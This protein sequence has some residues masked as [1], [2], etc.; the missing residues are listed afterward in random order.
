MRSWASGLWRTAPWGVAS[1]PARS[2]S[3]PL[4]TAA[5]TAT[6]APLHDRSQ[7]RTADRRPCSIRQSPVP[8]LSRW[9]SLPRPVHALPTDDEAA[10]EETL[11]RRHR[12]HPRGSRQ[13]G[14]P[15]PRCRSCDRPG[16]VEQMEPLIVPLSSPASLSPN[17]REHPFIWCQPQ[18][19]RSY[20]P[21]SRRARVS[22]CQRAEV[23]TIPRNNP[24][25]AGRPLLRVE[26]G[27][28]PTAPS[29]LLLYR[30]AER[31]GEVLGDRSIT[32]TNVKNS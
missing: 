18:R 32:V 7:G 10:L 11:R 12:A 13:L 2:T 28:L 25:S 24:S 26:I 4:S 14:R 3:T 17:S 21:R 1:S 22:S 29:F 16:E 8:R 27:T 15:R 31:R 23:P 30:R 20:G 19:P 5:T 9:P 6:P